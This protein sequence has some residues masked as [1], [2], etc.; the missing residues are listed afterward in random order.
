MG[1]SL[2]PAAHP[3]AKLQVGVRT[4]APSPLRNWKAAEHRCA[5]S[6]ECS[7]EGENVVHLG[8]RGTSEPLSGRE[9]K[10][11]KPLCPQEAQEIHERPLVIPD[12][13]WLPWP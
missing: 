6:R 8:E 13:E 12:A 7:G 9:T 1:A 5:L 10:I 2:L 4:D 3:Q 11:W